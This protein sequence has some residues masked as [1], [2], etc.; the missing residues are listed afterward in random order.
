MTTTPA[1]K[2]DLLSQGDL[3]AGFKFRNAPRELQRPDVLERGSSLSVS[4]NLLSVVHGYEKDG[5]SPATLVIV[6]FEFAGGTQEQRFISAT[7]TFTF[8]SHSKK[9]SRGPEVVKIAPRKKFSLDP[10]GIEEGTK[11]GTTIGASLSSPAPAPVTAT[12]TGQVSR[13]TTKASTRQSGGTVEG[14]I[15]ISNHFLRIKD[16]AKFYLNENHSQPNGISTCIQTAVL[17]KRK[18]D[19]KFKGMIDV[20]VKVEASLGE[21][22]RHS[23]I[24]R[25]LGTGVDPIV[26]DPTLPA[27]GKP[28]GVD[29]NDLGNVDLNKLW[30]VDSWT[31]LNT[32]KEADKI[33]G[34]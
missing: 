32:V 12:A 17:I 7:L 34:K 15:R 6:E 5:K 24:G 10:V 21:A 11:H 33:G 28:E 16:T 19:R 23:R 4:G 30:G 9:L 18:D 1:F 8:S 31:V 2:I 13:E 27:L 20:S 22:I 29:N 3:G 25:F 26:F 14:I